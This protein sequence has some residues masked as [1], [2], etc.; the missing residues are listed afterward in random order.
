MD[1]LFEKW[2]EEGKISHSVYLNLIGGSCEPLSVVDGRLKI[3]V[4]ISTYRRSDSLIRLL[5]SIKKQQYNNCEI[6]IVDDASNDDTEARIKQYKDKNSEQNIIYL[7]N[8][9]NLGVSESRKK[10]YLAASGDIVVFVDDDDY[11]IEPEYFS[12]LDQLYEKHS[13]CTMTV[14]STIQHFE[15]EGKYEYRGLNMPKLISSREYFNI[16]GEKYIT[17]HLF[18]VSL[19]N[20][21]LKD[22]HYEELL[23]FNHISLILYELLGK[24]NVYTVNRAVGIRTFHTG[25][26]TGNTTAEF[27]LANMEA[28]EDIYRRAMAAGLLDDPEVWRYRQ[29]SGTA[30][31]HFTNNQRITAKD[32][33]IF[34]WMKKHLERTKYYRFVFRIA[35]S[36]IRRWLR[37]NLN[38]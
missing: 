37:V 10:A 7:V 25:N 34:T 28:K 16:F 6:I 8:D 29:L 33:I 15:Q 27:I 13:D 32:R 12:M 9:R 22:V 31:Y 5:D 24:G 4:L 14:A 1:Q 11:Y 18:A 19:K 36:R 21:V 20:T 23:C 26:M 35:K 2:L 17:P 38:V 30:G 3:S